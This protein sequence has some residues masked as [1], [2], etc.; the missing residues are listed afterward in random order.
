MWE[1]KLREKAVTHQELSRNNV[2]L[3]GLWFKGH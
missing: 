1:V 2:P 3:G